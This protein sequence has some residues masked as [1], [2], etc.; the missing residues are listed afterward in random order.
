VP[1]LHQRRLVENSE[2]QAAIR[3]APSDSRRAIVYVLG[4]ALCLRALLA[5]FG[6]AY[7]HD[8]QIFFAPDTLSYFEPAHELV[9]H[10]RFSSGG[11]PEIIRTPGYPLLLAIGLLAGR[12]ILVT[13]ALQILVSCFIAY[14]VYRTAGIL[15][16]SER[17]AVTAAA[18]CA[19]EPLS[20]IY[21]STL[22]SETLFAALAT[23]WLYFLI[24][25]LE[26]RR[27]RDLIFAG[28]FLAASVYVRPI[29]Y[30]LPM[31]V[32][33]SLSVWII[34]KGQQKIGLMAHVALFLVITM[35]L[36]GAWQ[37]R[38]HLETGYSGF[39][40]I[41]SINLYFYQATSV[42]AAEEHV[43]FVKLQDQMG[44]S[45]NSIYFMRHPEQRR[46]PLAQ[47]LDYM[48]REAAHILRAHLFLY[49]GIHLKG[50][51]RVLFDPDATAYL[52]LF[53][54]YAG[55]GGILGDIADRGIWMTVTT[56]VLKKRLLFWSNL[57]LLPIELLY[58]FC[59]GAVLCSRRLMTDPMIIA[60]ILTLAYYI[61]ISGGPVGVGRFREPAMPIICVL[62]GYGLCLVLDRLRLREKSVSCSTRR[63]MMLSDV[64]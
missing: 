43:P 46:W 56:L 3:T 64:D 40:G 24:S 37:V 29:G 41:S 1:T 12:P 23:L 58:L 39:S 25:Y 30:F 18:L 55:G 34:L 50:M 4:L 42:L 19:I 52:K 21:A 59:A 62:A 9:S 45:D 54:L 26:H 2:G 20:I 53:R 36:T 10:H 31:L 47:R 15:F 44:Y 11:S 61:V 27:A 48:N 13:I 5:I 60:A 22:V 28:V 14:I 32:A 7:T 17:V 6:L 35:V 33:L 49:L 63:E 51:I 8:T 16:K 57:I 38:N